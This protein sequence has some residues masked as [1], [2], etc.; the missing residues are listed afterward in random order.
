MEGEKR[1][2]RWHFPVEHNAD[3]NGRRANFTWYVAGNHTN[4]KA[5]RITEH[6][7]LSSTKSDRKWN[8]S[9]RRLGEDQVKEWT[10]I[11]P[12]VTE[13]VVPTEV[14]EKRDLVKA[15]DTFM[16]ESSGNITSHTDASMSTPTPALTPT[17]KIMVGSAI[18][19]IEA[20]QE[21]QHTFHRSQYADAGNTN[22][23]LTFELE[24]VK[25]QLAQ[26][27][28]VVVEERTKRK[29]STTAFRQ[30]QAKRIRL[31]EVTKAAV[32][33]L[34]VS[35]Q[36][37]LLAHERAAKEKRE[38]VEAEKETIRLKTELRE[39]K[40]GARVA[41]KEA[42]DEYARC[43]ELAS[44]ARQTGQGGRRDDFA[45]KGI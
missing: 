5:D 42:S 3:G 2:A 32:E 39:A 9:Q 37:L 10:F 23:E 7:V 35:K 14:I 41:A 33:Q 36:E 29:R 19:Q 6:E 30:E 15:C 21:E 11:V 45:V 26:A 44:D 16:S 31:E 25:R 18:K 17:Q 4:N 27:Q 12:S 1:I 43:S 24:Q 40:E 20:T 8:A 38:R 28:A 13:I 34:E 22:L